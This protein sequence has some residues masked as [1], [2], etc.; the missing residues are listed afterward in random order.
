MTRYVGLGISYMAVWFVAALYRRDRL[1]RGCWC[2]NRYD[3][4][5]GDISLSFAFP[6]VWQRR[7][8]QTHFFWNRL[9]WNAVLLWFTYLL[10]NWNAEVRTDLITEEGMSEKLKIQIT[11]PLLYIIFQSVRQSKCFRGRPRT[12]IKFHLTKLLVTDEI[13]IPIIAFPRVF[14]S[15]LCTIFILVFFKISHKFTA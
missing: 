12:R 3:V 8:R 9:G 5:H 11:H 6:F 10:K 14:W 15:F 7:A 1:T 2:C 4:R 13:F